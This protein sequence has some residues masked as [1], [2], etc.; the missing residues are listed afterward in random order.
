MI[1]SVSSESPV[2]SQSIHTIRSASARSV[3]DVMRPN[4]REFP[5]VAGGV[6]LH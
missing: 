4:S 6:G 1:A 5:A 3:G 2:I